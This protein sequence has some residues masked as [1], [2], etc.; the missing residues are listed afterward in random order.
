M[1]DEKQL[2]FIKLKE[3][4]SAYVPPLVITRD[5][6]E[7]FDVYGDVKVT[8][9]KKTHDRVYFA[10]LE[11]WKNHVGFYFF[12]I[13]THHNMFSD[14][15]EDLIKL[16]KGKSCFHVKKEDEIIFTEI[17]KLLKKG[18]EIYRDEGWI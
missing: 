18:F 15:H 5:E 11:V 2:I 14:T 7:K 12:P 4:L 8:I 1:T 10:S 6:D 16:L 17:E 9:G 13:Y 3:L